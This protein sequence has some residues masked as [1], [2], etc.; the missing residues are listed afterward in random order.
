MIEP[1]RPTYTFI[2][3]LW[4]EPDAPQGDAGW[5]GQIRLLQTK[6]L[7]AQEIT[8]SNLGNLVRGI[9]ALLDGVSQT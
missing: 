3:R 1:I 6:G 7:P 5:R 2:L 4:R 8:F 9:R